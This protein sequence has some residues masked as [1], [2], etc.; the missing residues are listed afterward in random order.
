[1]Y[2]WSEKQLCKRFK[3]VIVYTC[4]LI[5][6]VN[7]SIFSLCLGCPR[8]FWALLYFFALILNIV[9]CMGQIIQVY[10]Q[11]V[12]FILKWDALIKD[13]EIVDNLKM[14][15]ELIQ[16]LKAESLLKV[17]IPVIK[18]FFHTNTGSILIVCT[19]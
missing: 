16:Y 10:H 7:I 19:L 17:G 3:L 6:I 9:H 18:N 4:I 1:M 5:F 12:A 13:P 8:I 2:W 11:T 14:F 15:M